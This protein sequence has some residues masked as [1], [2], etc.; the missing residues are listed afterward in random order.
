MAPQSPESA[1]LLTHIISQ[2]ES[3][4]QFLVSHNYISPSDASAFFSKLPNI[5]NNNYHQ[6]CTVP[7]A[8]R[9]IPVAPQVVQARALWAYN[10]NGEVRSILPES[11]RT[12]YD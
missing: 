2:L 5:S 12:A 1:A 6:S 4:I 3:N 11:T 7:P 9:S 10:E 8:P